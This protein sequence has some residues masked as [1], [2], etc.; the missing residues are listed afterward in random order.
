MSSIQ[1]PGAITAGVV[2]G[3]CVKAGLAVLAGMLTVLL[4][5]PS[6]WAAGMPEL[7]L[8]AGIEKTEVRDKEDIN[9]EIATGRGA[10]QFTQAAHYM[11]SSANPLA[12]QA[13]V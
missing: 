11:V 9:P 4:A 3:T 2:R 6:A 10:S 8:K 5:W 1:A 13:G 12:T 7:L